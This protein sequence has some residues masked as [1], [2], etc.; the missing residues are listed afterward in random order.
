MQ[1]N[2]I[3][4]RIPHTASLIMAGD[5]NDWRGRG[6]DDFALLFGMKDSSI[7]V[8]GKLART[9]PARV[10]I[11]PLDRIYVRGF[12]TKLSTTYHKGIWR[13]LSD[14]AALCVEGELN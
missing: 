1:A 5:F 2:Y 10:P 4:L 11:L 14:H 7:E 13:R 8:S 3:N 12:T 6:I 9:F